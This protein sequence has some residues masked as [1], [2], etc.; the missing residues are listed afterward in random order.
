MA[1]AGAR[2]HLGSPRRAAR[3][4]PQAAASAP[5]TPV[6]CGR[7]PGLPQ[8]P[9]GCTFMPIAQAI[10]LQVD[11]AMALQRVRIAEKYGKNYLCL[12]QAVFVAG[13]APP[14]ISSLAA[15]GSLA[16]LLACCL[17]SPPGFSLFSSPHPARRALCLPVHTPPS[18]HRAHPRFRAAVALPVTNSLGHPFSVPLASCRAAGVQLCSQL[19]HCRRTVGKCRKRYENVSAIAGSGLL[20]PPHPLWC[21]PGEVGIECQ[22]CIS[23]SRTQ[24]P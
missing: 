6:S 18:A 7:I 15:S 19:G 4:I 20:S 5:W 13:K 2:P 8:N 14:L 21:V 24:P 12:L 9:D 3:H 11:M 16:L 23:H 1:A 17:P 10:P 22:H